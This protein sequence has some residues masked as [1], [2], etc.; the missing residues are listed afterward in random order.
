MARYPSGI[1]VKAILTY[2]SIDDSGSAISVSRHAFEA[3]LRW[4]TSGGVR[5]VSLDALLAHPWDQVDAVA[6]TFDDGFENARGAVERMLARGLPATIFAVSRQAGGTNAWGGVSHPAIPT[7]PLLDWTALEQLVAQGA[8]VE[9]HTRTHRPLSR[10]SPT[11]MDDELLGCRDDLRARLGVN[12]AHLAYPY[13]DSD[14]AV[15]GRTGAFFRWGHTTE[16]QVLE[17]TNDPLC[18]PR[19]DMYYFQ[20]TGAIEQWGTA[21]FRRRVA[22]C[23]ARRRIRARLLGGWAPRARRT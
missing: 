23:R 14:G 20:A 6:I 7:L 17:S 21:A 13:G 10:L 22:W 12:S 1:P 2:H 8:A 18:L 11:E 19:L 9:A 4:M 15:V 16:F 5:I 3:H